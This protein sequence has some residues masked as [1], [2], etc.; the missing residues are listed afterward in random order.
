MAWSIPAYKGRRSQS[1]AEADGTPTFGYQGLSG[2]S[3]EKINLTPQ[4]LDVCATFAVKH[5]QPSD[6]NYTV[7]Q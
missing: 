4:Q 6:R 7:A 3:G 2:K 1:P 5:R